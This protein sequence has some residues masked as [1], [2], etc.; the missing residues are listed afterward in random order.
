M[1]REKSFC[2]DG[3]GEMKYEEGVV[4]E[5]EMVRRVSVEMGLVA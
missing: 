2:R 1:E 5:T 3:D 4:V